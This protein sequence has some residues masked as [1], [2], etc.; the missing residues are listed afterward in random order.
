MVVNALVGKSVTLVC[1][2]NAAPPPTI[3]WY[4][5]GRVV[6]ESANLHILAGGQKLEIRDSQVRDGLM[7]CSP[8]LFPSAWPL[9]RI[10]VYLSIVCNGC[11]SGPKNGTN[12]DQNGLELY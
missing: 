1:E 10:Y 3:T 9:L 12:I 8:L 7:Q 4:K 2:S 11:E 5:N 6:T